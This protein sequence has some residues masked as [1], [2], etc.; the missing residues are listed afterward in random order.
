MCDTRK[1]NPIYICG[2]HGEFRSPAEFHAPCPVCGAECRPVTDIN[3]AELI[4]G[5]GC[6]ALAVWIV[7]RVFL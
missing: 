3:A 7:L 4:L 6:V 2:K 5:L 1:L